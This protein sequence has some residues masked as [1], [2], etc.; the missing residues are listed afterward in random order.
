MNGPLQIQIT[1]IGQWTIWPG[2]LEPTLGPASTCYIIKKRD[3]ARYSS[4]PY[5]NTKTTSMNTRNYPV[6]DFI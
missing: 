2:P 3:L 4:C 5:R 1:G 6:I